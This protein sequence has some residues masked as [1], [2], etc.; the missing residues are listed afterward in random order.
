MFNNISIEKK[1]RNDLR[2]ADIIPVYK[3]KSKLS[4]EN[5]RPISISNKNRRIPLKC[6]K[7]ACM[8]KYRNILKLDFSNVSAVFGRVIVHSTVY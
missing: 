5:Y 7:G 8:T 4:Q 1:I 3:R 6:M 2:E